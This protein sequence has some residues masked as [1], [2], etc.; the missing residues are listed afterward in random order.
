MN[1]QVLSHSEIDQVQP[2]QAPW[3]RTSDHPKFLNGAA[4]A[5]ALEELAARLRTL[6]DEDVLWPTWMR[7]SFQVC[8]RRDDD[9]YMIGDQVGSAHLLTQA[10]GDVVEV[11]VYAEGKTASYGNKNTG[12]VNIYAASTRT[13]EPTAVA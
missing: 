8:G 7:V 2:E 9:R 6:G 1:T 11:D 5:D 4:M 3:Y 10:I 12:G 13:I